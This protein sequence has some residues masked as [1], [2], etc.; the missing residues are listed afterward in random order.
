MGEHGQRNGLRGLLMRSLPHRQRSHERGMALVLVAL[1][2]VVLMIFAALAVDIGGVALARRNDQNGSDA[3]A[4]AGVQD[5]DT[6]DAAVVL[7]VKRAVHGTLEVTFTDAQW[8]SCGTASTTGDPDA[9]DTIVGGLSC[10]TANGG[11]AQRRL[12][13]VRIPTQQY[14]TAF[15]RV[16][17]LDSFDHSAFAIAGFVSA[18]FG[19]ILPY[20]LPASSGDSA[21]LCLKSGPTPHS[22]Y[23]C[24]GPS[25]GSFGFLDFTYYGD[26]LVQT[27]Q[28][29]SGDENGRIAHNTA[30]GIDHDL[31]IYTGATGTLRDDVEC[32][33]L[34][35][36]AN[37]VQSNTGNRTS[38]FGQGI[39]SGSDVQ[40]PNDLAPYDARLQQ[41]TPGL[42]WDSPRTIDG[43]SLD[44]AP[45]WEFIDPI[46]SNGDGILVPSSCQKSVFTS[47]LASNYSVLPSLPA[48]V[49]TYVQDLPTKA[50][51]MRALIERCLTHYVGAA[52][53][54]RG[55]ADG[56]GPIGP[57]ADPTTC[58]SSGCVDI[59]F[60]R[61]SSTTEVPD[62]Y[63]IQYTPRFGYVPLLTTNFGTPAEPPATYRIGG[64]RAIWIQRVIGSC[65]AGGSCN[66]DFEPG[67]PVLGNDAPTGGGAEGMTA[68]QF[69]STILPNGLAG[70]SAPFD[71]G[72]NRFVRLV[73]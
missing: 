66:L 2:L 38:A 43:Y 7:A 34:E 50:S 70:S 4:L 10:I 30:L 9:V 49:R 39:Y 67:V 52:W 33:S 16:A 11:A 41:P 5:L 19:S 26:D 32:G 8:N 37:A 25:S 54:G 59:V 72:V 18:G 36:R 13:Q 69:P 61:N 21:Q 6:T 51:Q 53:D 63:D 22:E 71:I 27:T 60:G 15:A 44:N 31:Q 35:R 46:D 40:G 65:S 47:V 3:G 14:E 73:R 20:G 1:T 58:P 62:L 24:D 17:G 12:L 64:F 29:C 45:L 68:F 55:P 23:P 28:T 56:N 42:S 57:Q 48:D